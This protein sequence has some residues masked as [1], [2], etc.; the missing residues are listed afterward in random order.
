MDKQQARL[1]TL[2]LMVLIDAGNVIERALEKRLLPL[3][4]AVSQA[5]ILEFLYLAGQPLNPGLLAALLLQEPHSVSGLLNRLEDLDLITRSRTRRDR[6]VVLVALTE[7][8]R[9]LAAET[10]SMTHELAREVRDMFSSEGGRHA[11]ELI[12]NPR[13]RALTKVGVD[14]KARKEALKHVWD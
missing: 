1:D 13:D 2:P 8:G 3:G 4:I 11:L 14:E 7:S 10:M 6:Q 12:E 5:R 9:S